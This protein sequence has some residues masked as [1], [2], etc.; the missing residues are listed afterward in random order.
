VGASRPGEHGRGGRKGISLTPAALALVIGAALLHSTWNALAKRARA[1]L[2][3]LWSSVTLASL[4]LS[5]AA[6]WML[7]PDG[8][9]VAALP[10]VAAT[11]LLHALYFYAL[12]RAYRSGDFSRVYPIAR[13]LGVALVPVV[14][15]V[16]FEE[17]LSGLGAAGIVLVVGGIVALHRTPGRPAAGVARRG[18]LGA[19]TGWALL[20]G[21]TIAAYSLVDKAGVARLHPVPYIALLG[22]GSSLLLA[23][24]VLADRPGLWQEWRV[25]WRHLLVASAM[26][27]SAYLLVLF[28]FRLSKVGYVVAARELSIVLSAFIGS[29]W[30]GEG[31][32]GGRLVGAAVILAGVVCLALA[33]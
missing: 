9:P 23:P 2:P 17:G 24:A 4:L 19:G 27:L 20:T 5:P 14:A 16:A 32:L 22:L 11:V 31:A 26:N 30:L 12:G 33:R 6:L 29:W 8:L 21:L 10:F 7:P 3:F 13:G 28:A 25:N 18:G 1:P 15:W